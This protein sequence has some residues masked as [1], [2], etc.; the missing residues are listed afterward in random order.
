MPTAAPAAATTAE[1]LAC[2]GHVLAY[3]I[4]GRG[5][6]VRELLQL[7]S[8]NEPI[9]TAAPALMGLRHHE[10]GLLIAN[11]AR[12]FAGTRWA[13]G[14][15]RRRLLLS[16]QGVCDANQRIGRGCS[17]RRGVCVPWRVVGR[18]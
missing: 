17:A 4:R 10:D 15:A 9:T 13:D 6:S 7:A 5:P 1:A 12:M 2:I 11:D 16:L 3:R 18:A 8:T 14:R